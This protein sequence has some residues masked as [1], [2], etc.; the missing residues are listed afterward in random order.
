MGVHFTD[1]TTNILA[2]V[3]MFIM[4]FF[5][6]LVDLIISKKLGISLDDSLSDNPKADHYLHIRKLVLIGIFIV[7][8]LIVG[9]VTFFSRSASNDYLIHISL[10]QDLLNSVNID[11]GL[12]N[13]IK[14]LFTEGP[15]IAFSHVKIVN[16]DDLSQVYLNVVMFVPMGYLLPYVFDFF[17]KKIRL[18]VTITSFLLSVLIENLQLITKLGFYDTDDIISN[19]LGGF[20]GANLYIMFAY[21]LAHPNF[22][23]ELRAK[24]KWTFKARNKAMYPFISHSHLQR[25]T[26]L[27]SD[28]EAILD[29]YQ[30]KLGLFLINMK[31]FDEDTFYLFDYN[32]TQIEFHC[33]DSYTN[34]HPQNVIIAC[35]NS[36]NLKKRLEEFNIQTSE[37]RNDPYTNLRS[38]L[39]FAPENVTITIIEE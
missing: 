38:F 20:I 12:F 3:F 1:V 13:F 34:M 9:Y 22:R 2:T 37:Y 33:H 28:K 6:P 23:K 14:V 4:V 18:R 16:F 8:L 21:V 10:F 30:N 39:I 11:Y 24:F 29:F 25:V 36:Q 19:T 27:G 26:L 5:M 15:K 35:N 17:R 32:G 7:Y 31:E